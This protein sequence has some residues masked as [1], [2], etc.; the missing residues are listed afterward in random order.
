MAENNMLNPGGSKVEQ[1]TPTLKSPY[2][3]AVRIIEEINK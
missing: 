2:D 3:A 1:V